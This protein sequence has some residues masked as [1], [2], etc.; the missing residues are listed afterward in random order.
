MACSKLE[1]IEVPL[2][3]LKCK[4]VIFV[5]EVPPTV[6]AKWLH[7]VASVEVRSTRTTLDSQRYWLKISIQNLFKDWYLLMA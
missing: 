5:E 7:V 6:S 2:L 3:E 1:F 4:K